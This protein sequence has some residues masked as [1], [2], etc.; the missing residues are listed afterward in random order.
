M[1]VYIFCLL[2]HSLQTAKALLDRNI[3]NVYIVGELIW[4]FMQLLMGWE[5]ACL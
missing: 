2:V 4:H 3:Q 5:G 1:I